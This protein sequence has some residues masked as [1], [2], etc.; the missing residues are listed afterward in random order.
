M[1]RRRLFTIMMLLAGLGLS[2]GTRPAQAQDLTSPRLEA[3][4]ER[5]AE[6]FDLSP[7]TVEQVRAAVARNEEQARTPGFLWHVAADLESSLTPGQKEELLAAAAS[8]RPGT[9]DMRR[10]R[11]G[12]R[13]DRFGKHGHRRGMQRGE[14][15]PRMGTSALERL[16]P[17]LT[18]QQQAEI[19]RL[20]AAYADSARA[21][22]QQQRAAVAEVLTD[23][24]KAA[25]EEARQ[26]RRAQ[27]RDRREQRFEGRTA[28]RADRWQGAAEV[29]DLTEEQ[30]DELADLRE[31][32]REQ[33]Q[34]VWEQ[35]RAGG[36][37]RADV[38]DR[39]AEIRAAGQ[40]ARA[41]ILTPEQL[42]TMEIHRVLARQTLRHHWGHWGGPRR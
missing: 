27:V 36:L 31:R 25:L 34:A 20:R 26:E 29:L 17:D 32:Q 24:Q 40:S 38:P 37:D 30:Q 5:L 1:I 42:D 12:K 39:L 8:S 28:R 2:M 15:G 22:R 10:G 19:Q 13:G 6:T 14:R 7:G 3:S 9:A 4:V 21:L 35:V 23:Q 33:R 18:E 16:V 41:E 11:F